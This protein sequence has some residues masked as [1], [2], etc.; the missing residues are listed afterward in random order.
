[1]SDG[2]EVYD[3]GS[4]TTYNHRVILGGILGDTPARQKVAGL[5][6]HSARLA[7]PYCVCNSTACEGYHISYWTGFSKPVPVIIQ[8]VLIMLE[9]YHL[10]WYNPLQRAK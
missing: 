1:M 3:A 7:C 9:L 10:Y 5:S 6:G 2:F 4:Q 8:Q